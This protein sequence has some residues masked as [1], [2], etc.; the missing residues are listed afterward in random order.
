MIY[1]IILS[2]FLVPIASMI[3]IPGTI[4]WYPQLLALQFIGGLSF[5]S[6]FWKLNKFIAIFLAYLVFS[7]I[8]VTGATPRSLMCLM[9][10]YAAISLT[11]ITSKLKSDDLKLVYRCLIGISLLSIAYSISQ[12]FGYDPI[13]K[14]MF[15]GKEDVV[16]FM[17]S[18]NQ[19]GIYSSAN[20]FWST[21]C[22]P[23]A[24]IPIFFAKC[25]SA[26]IGL[27]SG[28][29]VYLYFK[30]NKKVLRDV[31][32]LIAILLIPWWHFC[33]KGSGELNERFNIWKLTLSQLFHGRIDSCDLSGKKEVIRA[34]PL[35]GFGLG[36]FF[37]FSPFSQ[38]KMWG[39]KDTEIYQGGNPNGKIQH[40]YEH[41]HND[42]IEALFE[43]GYVGFFIIMLIIISVVMVFIRSSKTDGIVLTFSSLVAQSV[44]SFSVYV[45]HAPVSLFM[46]CLT[47]GL[48]FAEVSNEK[49]SK[50]KP[51]TA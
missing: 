8:Y 45:F 20:A 32:V 50:I 9:I 15:G 40:F 7:Y 41:A 14:S 25:N 37:V 16:S 31:V 28:S 36:D 49:Q 44:S 18:H 13:F 2:I 23:M 12:F 22:I 39:F 10:G 38:Y 51:I 30:F 3:A 5:A 35:F 6:L 26:M 21:W 27:I 42:S 43:F 1:I 48:F 11:L 46:F 33:H 24:I 29:C 19:L 34:T 47:L 4:V 17:G